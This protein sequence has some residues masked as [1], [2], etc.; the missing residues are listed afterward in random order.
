LYKKRNGYSSGFTIIEVALVLAIAALIFL[1]VFL[2]VPALQRNQRIDAGNRIIKQLIAAYE[3][4]AANTNYWKGVPSSNRFGVNDCLNNE[5][6]S[7]G[8]KNWDLVYNTE[9]METT[10]RYIFADSPEDDFA[11]S[12]IYYDT[13][14][15]CNKDHRV[16]DE[17]GVGSPRSSNRNIALMTRVD[18]GIFICQ[19]NNPRRDDQRG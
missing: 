13:G 6:Q 7:G 10:G 12:A 2:A 17:D 18:K 3:T 9:Q 5:M 15:Y 16:V 11:I 8:L 14:A 19:D 4:C 1:V